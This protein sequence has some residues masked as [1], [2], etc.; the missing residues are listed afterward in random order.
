MNS[1]YQA[2]SKLT[3][4]ASLLQKHDEYQFGNKFRN[5]IA[6]TI[7]SKK[8]TKEVFIEHK[9]YFSFS[10]SHAPRKCETQN[11][12]LIKSRSEKFHNGNQQQQQQR[13]TYYG[14]TES[15]RQRYGRYN[16]STINLLQQGFRSRKT[17]SVGIMEVSPIDKKI[18]IKK[19]VRRPFHSK[20]F[21]SKVHSKPVISQE[22]EELVKLE[23]KEMLKKGAIRKFQPSE[24]EFVN[25]LFL[26]KRRMGVKG[27]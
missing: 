5:H 25:N 6:D 8:Q 21:Q 16:Y 15:H 1:Q 27:Q 26:V 14:Q 2:K 20:T 9:K 19:Y 18:L 7:K 13:Q 12:F 3:E 4:K 23:V 10:L 11:F 24:A 17:N 22:G